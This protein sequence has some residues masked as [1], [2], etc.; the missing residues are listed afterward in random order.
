MNIINMFSMWY[1]YVDVIELFES[2]KWG[3]DNIKPSVYMDIYAVVC[4]LFALDALK[5]RVMCSNGFRI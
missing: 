5:I 1:K 3:W 4:E 2:D